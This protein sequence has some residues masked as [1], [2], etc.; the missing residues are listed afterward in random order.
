[1]N[2]A[3]IASSMHDTTAEIAERIAAEIRPD[4]PVLCP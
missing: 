2:T 3:V 4:V 1:M